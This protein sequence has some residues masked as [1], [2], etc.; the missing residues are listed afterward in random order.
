MEYLINKKTI[1]K[2]IIAILTILCLNFIAYPVSF[3]QPSVELR[4]EEKSDDAGGVLAFPMCF[5]ANAIGDAANYIL[6]MALI[7]A[8]KAPAVLSGKDATEYINGDPSIVYSKKAPDSNP[9]DSNLPVIR[10]TKGAIEPMDIGAVKLTP[11]EIFAGKVAAL[12]AN[13][14]DT[15]SNTN[16]D[17]DGKLGGESIVSQLKGVIS[18]WYVALRNIAIVGLLSVLA[19]LAIRMIISSSVGDKAKYKQMFFD[20][21]IALCLIF[22]L[23]YIMS[24][25]M[26]LS[27]AVTDMLAGKSCEDGTIN[28]LIIQIT[29]KQN[30]D[31]TDKRFYSNFVNLARIKTQLPNAA[32]KLGYTGMYLFLTFLTGYYAFIYIKRVIMLAFLTM[33]APFVA[34]TYPLDKLKDGHAQAFNFWFKE[35]IFYAMLQPLHMLLYTIFI[36]SAIDIAANN[37]LYAIVAMFFMMPAE[38]LVKQMFGIHGQT[39]NN[40]APFA[41]GAIAGSLMSKLGKPPKQ[42]GGKGFGGDKKPRIARNPEGAS[43]NSLLASGMPPSEGG[44]D[45]VGGALSGMA[46]SGLPVATMGAATAAGTGAILNG[47][48]SV[49]TPSQNSGA[50]VGTATTSRRINTQNARRNTQASQETASDT[51]TGSPSYSNGNIV[52]AQSSPQGNALHARQA[53]TRNNAG[54]RNSKKRQLANSF[55]RA[56]QRRYRAAGGGAGIAKKLL[57]GTAKA[58]V[59]ATIGGAGLLIGGA[60][61]ALDGPEGFVKGATAGIVGGGALG[62][63]IAVGGSNLIDNT[64]SGNNAVGSFASEVWNGGINESNRRRAQREYVSNPDTIARI[65]EDHPELNAK[66]IR[67]YANREYDM[68]YDSKTDDPELAAKAM[69]LEDSFLDQGMSEEDAH[70][71]AAGIL[72]ATKSFDKSVFYNDKKLWEAEDALVDNLVSQGY[73]REEAIRNTD[74]AFQDLA[75]LYGVRTNIQDKRQRRN[76]AN[77]LNQQHT[78][79]TAQRRTRTQNEHV[80]Q[81]APTTQSRVRTQSRTRTQSEPRTPSRTRTQSEPRTPSRTR[82]QSEPRTPSR[83]RTP[84]EPRTPSRTRTP[85]V[86][87]TSRRTRTET[88]GRTTPSNNNSGENQQNI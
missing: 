65:Q 83:T 50:S 11:A 10:I 49:D 88:T 86:T 75:N 42:A 38:K 30:N 16:F 64:L 26:T 24:F 48:T 76:Q 40:I 25:A 33:I 36:S 52:G 53:Y 58:A 34:L 1:R 6:Q 72:N 41:G 54:T 73:S 87:R 9:D 2:I 3:A 78:R 85:S 70:L 39:E 67:E 13:F 84:S 21:V 69:K 61:G 82:T 74:G 81:S 68:L 5:L 12:D 46:D 66:Q 23:H 27:T 62:N 29:D 56:V 31:F 35:Y 55:K 57:A 79:T 20:W 37:I 51:G 77:T 44:M 8:E 32:A 14:F 80:E 60:L 15:N 22:F 45:N 18:G 7:G 59:R 71:R 17:T 63:R 4:P 47:V 28:Q 19:Y 43:F